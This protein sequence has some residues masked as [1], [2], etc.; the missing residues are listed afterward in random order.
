MDQTLCVVVGFYF[1]HLLHQQ[2]I[3]HGPPESV[4]DWTREIDSDLSNQNI[5]NQAFSRKHWRLLQ[6]QD[7]LRT[8]EELGEVVKLITLCVI[9]CLSL[10]S[11]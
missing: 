2:H 3:L 5:N 10:F 9:S 6:C 11:W 8:F 7:G 1:A 4:F